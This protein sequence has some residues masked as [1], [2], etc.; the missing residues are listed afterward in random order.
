MVGLL[1]LHPATFWAIVELLQGSTSFRPASAVDANR[2]ATTMTNCL[3]GYRP[4][5]T[6]TA[7]PENVSVELPRRLEIEHL[8]KDTKLADHNATNSS[9]LS[10]SV[11]TGFFRLTFPSPTGLYP[12]GQPRSS[13][14]RAFNADVPGGFRRIQWPIVVRPREYDSF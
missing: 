10:K 2:I 3:R 1:Q 14:V 11:A 13:S 9:L 12:G 5:N 4:Q 8:R 6:Y 7:G